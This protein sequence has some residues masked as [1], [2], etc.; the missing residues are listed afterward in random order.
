MMLWILLGLPCIF[1]I[2]AGV[3]RSPRAILVL[4]ALGSIAVAA[5]GGFVAI[6][7]I[8]SPIAAWENNL[9]LDVLSAYHL[10]IIVLVFAFASFYAWGHFVPQIA[11]GSFGKS[12]ARRFGASWFSFLASMILVLMSNNIGLLWV[13][14]ETTTL[15]SALLVSLRPDAA[16]IRAAWSYLMICS[17][18]IAMALLGTFLLA[19][20]AK[21]VMGV[22]A[23]EA[24]SSPF[25]WT[26]LMKI[27]HE[28][29]PDAVKLAFVFLLV[30]Y[31]TKA[32]LAPMHSWLPDAHGQAPAPVSAVLSAVLLNCA[33]YAICRVVPV[34]NIATDGAGWGIL[35]PFGA[36]SVIVAALHV[37]REKDMKRL[38]AYCSV[39]HIGIIAL[40]VG[41][42]APAIALFHT[43]NH[44][45]AKMAAFFY[46]GTIAHDRGT[47]KADEIGGLLRIHPVIGTGL[48]ASILAL[49][50]MPPSP[51]FQSELWLVKFGISKGHYVSIGVLLLGVAILAFGLVKPFFGMVWRKETSDIRPFATPWHQ[52]VITILPLAILLV[53]GV[54]MP[55]PLA[56]VIEQAAAI[57]GVIP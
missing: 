14:M 7:A 34:V 50:A 4:A 9:R 26:D 48:I 1:A 57:I 36:L 40:A 28:M 39:E 12:T 11:E 18:G 41:L 2:A 56:N 43:L 46:A 52:W 32:G 54:W 22:A 47:K 29:R 27:A 23:L 6:S 13:A 49:I 38:L 17:V 15:A 42:G 35:V 20:E 55:T 37:L 3:L 24:G 44:S 31:G 8:S 33:L 16:S 5:F 45:V 51:V 21:A 10:V 19:G 30:G 53:L 25:L